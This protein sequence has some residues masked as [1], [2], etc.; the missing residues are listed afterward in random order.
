VGVGRLEDIGAASCGVL[1]APG[2]VNSS[3]WGRVYLAAVCSRPQTLLA[4][5]TSTVWLQRNCATYSI[6]VIWC[7]KRFNQEHGYQ[8]YS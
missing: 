5:V 2:S 4:T 1:A 3:I 6:R 8:R 7:P